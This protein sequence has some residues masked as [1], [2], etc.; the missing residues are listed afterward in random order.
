[1]AGD[2]RLQSTWDGVKALLTATWA[3][4][5][6]QPGAA[7]SAQ[8]QTHLSE[9]TAELASSAARLSQTWIDGKA[10]LAETWGTAS[11]PLGA[12]SVQGQTHSVSGTVVYPGI[13]WHSVVIAPPLSSSPNRITTTPVDLVAG[14]VIWWDDPLVT[15]YPSG[16]WTADPSVAEFQVVITDVADGTFS[17]KDTQTVFVGMYGAASSTQGQVHLASGSITLIGSAT[18]TQ[19][20]VHLASGRIQLIG[21]ATSTQEQVHAGR[22]VLSDALFGSAQ[23]AQG[24]THAAQG[25]APLIGSASSSQEQTHVGYGIA[26]SG[27]NGLGWTDVIEGGLTAAQLMRLLVSVVAADNRRTAPN[28]YV[29]RDV[30]NTKDRCTFSYDPVTRSRTLTIIDVD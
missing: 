26:G 19:E 16:D 2:A 5:V 20:Q 18:S 22:G 30:A 28:T 29:Y 15:V 25:I 17:V 7:A 4:S 14:D 9:G 10:V 13:G 21:S 3:D 12:S 1:M 11:A 23:S 8:G 24:Q 6:G 27:G